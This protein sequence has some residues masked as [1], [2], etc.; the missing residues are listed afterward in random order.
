MGIEIEASYVRQKDAVRF[1]QKEGKTMIEE[2]AME[3]SEDDSDAAFVEKLKHYLESRGGQDYDLQ[4][5]AV[6]HMMKIINAKTELGPPT[7]SGMLDDAATKERAASDT[8]QWKHVSSDDGYSTVD[9]FE[10]ECNSQF[11]TI[12]PEQIKYCPMC[13]KRVVER[14]A[15]E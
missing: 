14:A 10:S 4:D 9:Y 7:S 15:H 1:C 12:C 3:Y 5:W 13:G 8:C 11:L 2:D 6:D